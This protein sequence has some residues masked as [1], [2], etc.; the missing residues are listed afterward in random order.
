MGM[1]I[2]IKITKYDE[3]DNLYK[4]L[5]LYRPGETY[6]YDEKGNKIVDNPDYEIVRVFNGYRNSEM[7]DGMKNGNETDGYGYFPTSPIRL[8]SLEPKLR[9]EIK[10]H[11]KAQGYFDFWEINLAEWKAYNLEHSTVVDYDAN[12]DWDEIKD[13]E[14]QKKNPIISL[15]QEICNYCSFAEGYSWDFS[16]LSD[17]KILIY[18]DW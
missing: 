4:E 7:F 8:N 5:I 9:E 18:F 15:F 11:Q 12:V 10:K 2:H 6:H 14:P 3:I 16:N 1:D 13:V 17:Y